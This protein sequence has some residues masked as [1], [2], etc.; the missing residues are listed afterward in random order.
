MPRDFVY[1]FEVRIEMCSEGDLDDPRRGP[2]VHGGPR[3][4][5]CDVWKAPQVRFE[6]PGMYLGGP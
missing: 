6:V 1:E 2:R 5:S 3:E 4:V